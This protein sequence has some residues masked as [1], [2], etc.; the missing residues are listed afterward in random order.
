MKTLKIALILVL[1]VVA[2]ALLQLVAEKS[3][4]TAF[5]WGVWA[6]HGLVVAL[7][8]VVSEPAPVTKAATLQT[9]S[10][11]RLGT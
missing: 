6:F 3:A 4:L 5:I 9:S 10:A 7:V 8:H 1:T 2:A 11:A